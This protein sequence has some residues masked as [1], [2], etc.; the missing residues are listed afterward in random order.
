MDGH[1]EPVPVGVSGELYIGGAGVARGY[2]GRSELTA[3]RFL[4][5]P[6]VDEPGARIY[7]TGDLGRFLP[8]GNIEFLGRNDFQVKIRGFRIEL[9]EIEARLAEYPGVRDAVVVAREE[10][11]GDKRLVAYYTTASGEGG[12]MEAAQLRAHLS[13]VLPEY[14]VPAAYVYLESL[15][16]TANG[17]L[18]RG[19]LPAPE[20][21]AYAVRGYEEPQGETERI[22]ADIWAEVLKLERVGRHDNFF[23]LGG[24]SLLA[25]T[26]IGRMRQ[27][28][29][30]ADVRSLF[31]APTLALLAAAVGAPSVAVPP[32]LIP[33]DCSAIT[34]GMLP[35]VELTQEEIDRIVGAVP[36]GAANV[37]DIYPLS[38]LQE[39]ILFHHL[40]GGEGDPY[41]LAN[42]FS[43]D[44]RARLD[45]YIE[46]LQSVIDRHD[47]LR[48]SVSWEGLSQ[49]V[50]VVWRK[51]P[52]NVEEIELEPGG[53]ASEQLYA[54]FDPRHHRMDIGQAP[55]LRAYL[56]HDKQ[57]DL[58]LLLALAPSSDGGPH[59]A[60]G[61][62]GGDR[63]AF[64]GRS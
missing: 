61:D 47:I 59:D 53:D 52:L 45:N 41:L 40:M 7:K 44:T 31:V 8:D 9:G 27:K 17:K 23:E 18:D 1:G 11:V 64:A 34:P 48:S 56:S 38:P 54:Q 19:R 33:P 26:L 25:I 49:A 43:F 39:G 58:W 62:A 46:A 16:L 15:P 42:Q 37:Q 3:E 6:F 63:G 57:K 35:L 30:T 32:N 12:A 60:G 10:T 28:G 29:I 50:Q 4:A 2:L 20:L 13:A 24:H 14:M 55:M 5:D 36:G 51:A 22:L 21:D